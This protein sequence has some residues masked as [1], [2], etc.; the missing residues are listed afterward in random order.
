MRGLKAMRR[1]IQ[2]SMDHKYKGPIAIHFADV[3]L[4]GKPGGSRQWSKDNSTLIDVTPGAVTIMVRH[5]RLTILG[6][7][8]TSGQCQK[9][10]DEA[11]AF[12]KYL[13]E[14]WQASE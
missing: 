3:G 9:A 1:N 11:L 12:Q 13:V 5:L 7:R 8:I 10:L 4:V 6:E 2:Q 14:L